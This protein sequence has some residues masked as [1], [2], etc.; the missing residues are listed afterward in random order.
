M[1]NYAIPHMLRRDKRSAIINVSSFSA[2]HPC[3]YVTNYSATKAFVD[4]FSQALSLE[5]ENQIDILSLR[6]MYV[7][8]NMSKQRASFTVASRNQCAKS[9][10][11]MLG[12]DY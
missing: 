7:E 9:A 12:I 3:P 5:Y 1:S 2:E 11:R 4:S 8:S 10:I 6:P